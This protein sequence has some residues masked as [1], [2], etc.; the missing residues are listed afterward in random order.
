[1]KKIIIL[2][3]APGC[4]KSTWA[5][6]YAIEHPQENVKVISSDEIRKEICGTYLDFTRQDEVWVLFEKRIVEYAKDAENVTVILDALNDLDVLRSKYAIIAKHHYDRLVLVVLVKTFEEIKKHNH[7][8]EKEKWV[9]DDVLLALYQKYQ[10]P[11][12][13]VISL[14]DEYIYIDKEF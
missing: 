7:E 9:P 2:S 14:F 13:A 1:M 12:P 11:C 5:K 8:R 4:G 6:K 3:A 10:L